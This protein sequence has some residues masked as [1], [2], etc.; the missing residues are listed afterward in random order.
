MF[1]FFLFPFSNELG[2]K[3]HMGD[4]QLHK[5]LGAGNF[6]RVYLAEQKQTRKKVAI[7][8]IPR[9]K[10]CDA[11][12]VRGVMREKEILELAKKK[13]HP[14]L[15]GLVTYFETQHDMCL[16]MDYASGGD[17]SSVMTRTLS[18]ETSV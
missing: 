9:E 4:F 18:I 13:N 10:V 3:T 11:L 1:H 15:I 17:L 8:M 14:F 12:A 5:L 6:G 2:A 16:A 7:K